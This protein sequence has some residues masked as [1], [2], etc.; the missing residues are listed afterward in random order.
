MI[1]KEP[2][3]WHPGVADEVWKVCICANDMHRAKEAIAFVAIV[4]SG[5]LCD[6]HSEDNYL[7][8]ISSFSGEQ[9][10]QALINYK[11]QS[12][13]SVEL[14]IKKNDGEVRNS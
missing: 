1:N 3:K 12:L 14:G 6:D 5:P 8:I 2:I 13:K 11:N 7:K 10:A 4:L 9:I